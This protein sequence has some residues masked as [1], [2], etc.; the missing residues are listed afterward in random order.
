MEADD[1][2]EYMCFAE[3]SVGQALWRVAL[4]VRRMLI[5]IINIKKYH[6]LELCLNLKQ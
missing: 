4:K 1:A 3:N 5:K 2:G 6:R